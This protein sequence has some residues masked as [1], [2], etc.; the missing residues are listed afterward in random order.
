MPT[1]W[2]IT[3]NKFKFKFFI[4]STAPNPKKVGLWWMIQVR[5][6][7]ACSETAVATWNTAPS[8]G[9]SS[10]LSKGLQPQPHSSQAS[11]GP[12]YVKPDS[13][14][15]WP[16]YSHN[17][18]S[19]GTE[20]HNWGITGTAIVQGEI[21]AHR[22]QTWL[23]WLWLAGGDSHRVTRTILSLQYRHNG[24]LPVNVTSNAHYDI[25]I[26]KYCIKYSN[27]K[28]NAKIKLGIH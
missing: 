19:N 24:T 9:P 23:R 28:G 21:W 12:H 13:P 4:A 15:Y 7:L 11:L 16:I 25:P 1:G 2:Q 27:G 22:G 10:H 26:T 8:V 18:L 6:F 5:P 20:G 17:G 14:L 3:N